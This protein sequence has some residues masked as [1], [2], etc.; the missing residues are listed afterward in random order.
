MAIWTQKFC[1]GL[2]TMLALLL[3]VACDLAGTSSAPQELA[4]LQPCH[5]RAG[6]RHDAERHRV[7]A[8]DLVA[9]EAVDVLVARVRLVAVEALQ[10]DVAVGDELDELPRPGADG[11]QLHRRRVRVLL[12]ND[13]DRNAERAQV[14]EE[15]R[16]RRLQRMT[17][18]CASGRL[19]LLDDVEDAAVDADL[20]VAI[21][22]GDHVLGRHR[23]AVVELHA[24]RSLKCRSARPR[25]RSPPGRARDRVHVLVARHQRLEHVHR[26]VARRDRR[27]MCIWSRLLTLASCA[28]TMFPPVL[29]QVKPCAAAAPGQRAIADTVRKQAPI[30]VLPAR[31]MSFSRRDGLT[32]ISNARCRHPSFAV[33]NRTSPVRP[34]LGPCDASHS[35]SMARQAAVW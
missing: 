12:R 32:E 11:L 4:R 2:S 16:L 9:A 17:K 7:E 18:V 27:R 28:K 19:P 1:S 26:D 3:S 34:A 29:G 20:L 31:D 22:R 10:L 5:A 14:L 8:G 23:L 15:R 21:E 13:H 30:R 33:R 25:S 24:F 6:L 35:G